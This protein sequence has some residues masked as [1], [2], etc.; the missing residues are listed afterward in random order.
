MAT[1]KTPDE[2]SAKKVID[3]LPKTETP[4]ED[5][6]T[7]AVA[8]A[9]PTEPLK[10]ALTLTGK[11]G[12]KMTL[13]EDGEV[14]SDGKQ[15]TS[16]KEDITMSINVGRDGEQKTKKVKMQRQDGNLELVKGVVSAKRQAVTVPK[17]VQEVADSSGLPSRKGKT[18]KRED[19]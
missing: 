12:K 11:G 16:E 1:P 7:Q 19:R 14:V 13:G 10:I 4:N 2:K 17:F 6:L 15:P 8:A 5:K 18:I 9:V 3:A